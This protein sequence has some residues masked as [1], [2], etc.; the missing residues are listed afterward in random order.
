MKRE[1]EELSDKYIKFS[2]E[3]SSILTKE[4]EKADSL[5][6]ENSKLQKLI[7][8]LRNDNKNV[9]NK[10][11]LR[12]QELKECQARLEIKIQTEEK[13]KEKDLLILSKYT[14]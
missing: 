4:Q 1:K 5:N 2:Q 14:G 12:E 6:K 9:T 10:L 8:E 7:R 3:Q 13:K 11:N